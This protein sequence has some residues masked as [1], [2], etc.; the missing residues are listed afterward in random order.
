MFAEAMSAWNSLL[1]FSAQ[2]TP[3]L[4]H[5]YQIFGKLSDETEPRRRP[6]TTQPADENTASKSA[7]PP[8]LKLKI[9]PPSPLPKGLFTGKSSKKVAAASKKSATQKQTPSPVSTEA[10]VIQI[11]PHHNGE[12]FLSKIAVDQNPDFFGYPFTGRTT[13]KKPGNPS[14]PQRDPEPSDRREC[15]ATLRRAVELGITFIGTA[16]SYGPEVAE[17]IIAEALYPYAKNIVIATKAGLV[18]PGPGVWEE[19]GRPEHLRDACEESLRRLKLERIDLFQL[20]RIDPKVPLEDQIG[21]LLERQKKGKIRHIGLSEVKVEQIKTVRRVAP[22][23]SVQNQYNLV[24]R[25]S[26]DVLG[27][28]TKEKIGFVPWFPL[29]AGDLVKPGGAFGEAV[30]ELGEDGTTFVHKVKNRRNAG[31]HPQGAV[32]ELKSKNDQTAKTA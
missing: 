6:A 28:C 20:H 31:N 2:L 25:Q 32:A 1:A 24:D 23:V 29:A 10:L 12:V 26:E 16:D 30:E 9:K 18:R 4:I 27:N 5:E 21:V 3:E 7:G 19:N 13:P 17:R 22:V 8:R 14:Y 11:V 15:I